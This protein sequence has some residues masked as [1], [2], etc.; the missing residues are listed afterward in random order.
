MNRET[1]IGL[2]TVALNKMAWREFEISINIG[3]PQDTFN[4][5]YN[6]AIEYIRA[7]LK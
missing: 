4:S 1:V 6:E 2:V 3:K 7:N 5:M